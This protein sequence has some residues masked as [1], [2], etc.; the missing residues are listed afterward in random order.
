MHLLIK[1]KYE[2]F[3]IKF[4]VKLLKHSFV[5]KYLISKKFGYNLNEFSQ[6]FIIIFKDMQETF[7]IRMVIKSK[8]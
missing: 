8:K 5:K 6:H 4:K 2:E 7:F 1:L 3:N